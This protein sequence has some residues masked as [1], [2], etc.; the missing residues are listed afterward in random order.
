MFFHLSKWIDILD[1]SDWGILKENDLG[2]KKVEAPWWEVE[3]VA[4]VF[5]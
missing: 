3:S 4:A 2:T 1:I 5:F